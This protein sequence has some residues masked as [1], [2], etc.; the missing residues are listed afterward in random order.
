[1]I[2]GSISKLFILIVGCIAAI[3]LPIYFSLH[4]YSPKSTPA[5]ILGIVG[6]IMMVLGALFYALR[7]RIK[8]FRTLGQMSAWLDVHIT[9]CILGPLLVVYHTGFIVKSPNAAIAFYA[10][11]VVVASGVIGRYIYRHFQFSLS[12]ERTNLREMTE[13]ID[14]LDQ[15]ISQAFLESQSILATIRSFF[16]L[17]ENNKKPGL[18]RSIFL[19]I[20]MD[21]LEK[22]LRRQI[23]RSA[24]PKGK[25]SF[26][27]TGTSDSF[28]SLVI[29][30]IRL[31]KNISALEATTRLFAYWHKLHVPFIWIL[32]FTLIVHITAVL[33]F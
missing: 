27:K 23:G 9:L 29:K 15:K 13:E 17:R 21:Q 1:M 32:A 4:P 26:S 28:E 5:L 10:M 18:F 14:H 30:R 33:I 6:S 22:I 20:R 31:E 11:L 2:K 8:A 7:K 12:G 16:K 3:V 24:R 25:Q 19:M